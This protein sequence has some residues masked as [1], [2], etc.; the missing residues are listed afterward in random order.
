[1]IAE[2]NWEDRNGEEEETAGVESREL[3]GVE[4]PAADSRKEQQR[5]RTPLALRDHRDGRVRELVHNTPTKLVTTALLE[6]S[7]VLI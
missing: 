4:L 5:T 6:G 7:P 2:E 3:L 1:M